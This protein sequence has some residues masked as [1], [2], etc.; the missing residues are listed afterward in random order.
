MRLGRFVL[1]NVA[2]SHVLPAFKDCVDFMQ[3]VEGGITT[4]A[5]ELPDD[6]KA[7]P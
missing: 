5:L 6:L 3:A 7:L 4:A 2:S 1:G